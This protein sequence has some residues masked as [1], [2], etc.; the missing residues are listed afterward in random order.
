MPA[1][2]S[3][4]SS[5]LCSN[6]CEGFFKAE[7]LPPGIYEIREV[8]HYPT[9]HDP[10]APFVDGKDTIGAV[11]GE[12]VGVK[13]NDRFSKSC[14]DRASTVFSMISGELRQSIISGYVS[15]TSP[16]GECV[17]PLSNDHRGVEGVVIHLYTTNRTLVESTQTD[18]MDL[19]IPT[20]LRP[21]TYGIVEVQPSGYLDGGDDLGRVDGDLNGVVRGNDR[22]NGIRLSS[23]QSGTMYNFCEQLPAEI[24]G[25]VWHDAQQ[26]WP[27]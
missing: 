25:T 21:G 5:P 14:W 23:G 26:Q 8:N 16:D 15:V 1:I 7:A 3:T 6:K 2:R 20:N 24:C 12:M 13:S 27:P 17:D 11:D 9:G 18:S 22:F 19:R 4:R 10:L